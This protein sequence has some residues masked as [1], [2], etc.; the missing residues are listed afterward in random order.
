MR[1]RRVRGGAGRGG[2]HNTTLAVLKVRVLEA[3]I[4]V[5]MAG[6]EAAAATAAA[7]AARRTRTAKSSQP[8]VELSQLIFGC[9]GEDA[10]L[11]WCF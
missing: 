2:G 1:G 7:A 4:W 6:H 5:M 10:S 3:Y 9:F 8:A 11:P